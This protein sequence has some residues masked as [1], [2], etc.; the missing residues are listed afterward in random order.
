MTGRFSTGLEP[1]EAEPR[2]EKGGDGV[3]A[4]VRLHDK[5]VKVRVEL[6]PPKGDRRRHVLA[7]RTLLG[8]AIVN[9]K[10]LKVRE[11]LPKWAEAGLTVVTFEA[12]R[13]FIRRLE[14]VDELLDVVPVVLREPVGERGV[15]DV[16]VER[17]VL[18]SPVEALNGL[19]KLK[20]AE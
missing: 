2:V 4:N 20:T 6:L 14:E 15:V 16:V 1:V 19:L 11:S 9:P 5:S 7:Q 3:V 13:H 8:V 17:V 12:L 10:C 18:K